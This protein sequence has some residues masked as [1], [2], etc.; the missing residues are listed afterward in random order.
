MSGVLARQPRA[1]YH[2]GKITADRDQPVYAGSQRQT[3]REALEIVA[4]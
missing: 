4:G 3:R 2:S 1:R